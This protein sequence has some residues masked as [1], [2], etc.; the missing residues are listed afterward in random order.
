[1]PVY[2]YITKGSISKSTGYREVYADGAKKLEHRAFME[3]HLDRKLERGEI[4][5]HKNH[6]RLDNRIENLELICNQAEH[7]REHCKRRDM[8]AMSALGHQARWGYAP[9]I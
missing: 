1:M 5:H 7:A 2:Q 6:D 4:V 8:K 3:Q 9:S